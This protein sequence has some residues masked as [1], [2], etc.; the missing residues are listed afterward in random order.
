M[1]VAIGY[2]RSRRAARRVAADLAD[3]RAARR[4]VAAATRELGGLDVLVNSAARVEHTPFT[5][6][7]PAQYD[8]LL[9]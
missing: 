1:D 5:T 2:H 9:V 4:L 7:S 3:P 8:R 6:T